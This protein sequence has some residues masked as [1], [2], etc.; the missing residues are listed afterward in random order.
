MQTENSNQL[1]LQNRV[2]VIVNST[3]SNEK[4]STTFDS[5]ETTQPFI[6][7]V[8]QREDEI[9]DIQA[10]NESTPIKS[11]LAEPNNLQPL[12]KIDRNYLG[13]PDSVDHVKDEGGSYEVKKSL[14]EF[15]S[16]NSSQMRS[17]EVV[18]KLDY[19]YKS[20]SRL[21][22]NMKVTAEYEDD[23]FGDDYGFDNLNAIP[24]SGIK[25]EIE[26]EKKPV[27]RDELY[28]ID[29]PYEGKSGFLKKRPRC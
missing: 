16:K 22:N 15:I 17:S 19:D 26:D 18:R 12:E 9:A 10:Y 4:S 21:P 24:D 6:G 20:N 14:F 7:I 2:E 3:Y 5:I 27:S 23:E 28:G 13:T 8:P 29:V 1:E 25:E 11:S